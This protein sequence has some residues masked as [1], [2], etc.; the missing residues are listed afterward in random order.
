MHI[1]HLIRYKKSGP[2]VVNIANLGSRRDQ[3]TTNMTEVPVGQGSG[4][5]FDKTGDS[6]HRIKMDQL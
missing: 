6:A 4:F 1:L 2:S 3:F 5:I